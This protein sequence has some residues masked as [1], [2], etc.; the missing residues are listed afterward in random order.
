MEQ[1]MSKLDNVVQLCESYDLN[2]YTYWLSLIEDFVLSLWNFETTSKQICRISNVEK[3][4]LNSLQKYSEHIAKHVANVN[5]FFDSWV[6]ESCKYKQTFDYK[7]KQRDYLDKTII[8]TI[9][10]FVK[11]ANE[12]LFSFRKNQATSS[13]NMK[14]CYYNY[15]NEHFRINIPYFFNFGVHS[16]NVI[17][18]TINKPQCAS[19]LPPIRRAQE[20]ENQ[21][22]SS[23]V[24][25]EGIKDEPKRK[26]FSLWGGKYI[27]SGA[28]GCVTNPPVKCMHHSKRSS[29]PIY[30]PETKI[31]KVFERSSSANDEKAMQEIIQTI[32]PKGKWTLPMHMLCLVRDF[33]VKDEKHKCH[34][35]Q[36]SA[37]KKGKFYHQLIYENGGKDLWKWAKMANNEKWS[38]VRKRNLFI[39]MCRALRPIFVG[40]ND[41]HKHKYLHMDL[42]PPNMLFDGKK[43]FVIDFGLMD[44]TEQVYALDNK[45]MTHILKYDYP[46]YPPEFKIFAHHKESRS[47]DWHFIKFI[48][49]FG[50]DSYHA[51]HNPRLDNVKKQ[52]DMFFKK[53]LQNGRFNESKLQK[54]FSQQTSKIDIYSLGESFLELYKKLVTEDTLFTIQMK[55]LLKRMVDVDCTTRPTWEAII[56]MY[57]SFSKESIKSTKK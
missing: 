3:E 34:L 48:H 2:E 51:K 26:T 17:L 31:G 53:L 46:Y 7:I 54:T 33:S 5:A 24:S 1:P 47:S 18:E 12:I 55:H 56:N 43:L 14:Q 45:H 16:T 35:L 13:V 22:Y 39:K 23:Q 20:Q 9:H 57:D 38:A 32:D 41:L 10:D 37:D 49:N 25:A 30:D 28:Y 19:I 40:L 42:K 21:Y 27:A 29:N 11:N 52:Y 15:T 4:D 6:K 44:K 36:G 8:P 50:Y